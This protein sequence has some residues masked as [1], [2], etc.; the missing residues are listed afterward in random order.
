MDALGVALVL[1]LLR[2]RLRPV[3]DPTRETPPLRELLSDG[4]PGREADGR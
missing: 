4:D 1:V 2:T 3:V